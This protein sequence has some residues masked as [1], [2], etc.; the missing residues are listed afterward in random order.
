MFAAGLIIAI[1]S[2]VIFVVA[3][4]IWFAHIFSSMTDWDAKPLSAFRGV[5]IPILG[6]GFGTIGVLV[7]VGM[8]VGAL[9]T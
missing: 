8:M 5:F 4:G 9:F 3:V 1:V 2:A 6:G 7:G